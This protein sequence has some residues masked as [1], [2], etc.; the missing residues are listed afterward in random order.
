VQTALVELPLFTAHLSN[1]ATASTKQTFAVSAECLPSIT[2]QRAD[3]S[4]HVSGV[5][6]FCHHNGLRGLT[7]IGLSSSTQTPP[8]QH[9]GEFRGRRMQQANGGINMRGTHVV[10]CQ[11]HADGDDMHLSCVSQH[12]R[13]AVS[14]MLNPESHKRSPVCRRGH[15]G[16][17]QPQS[18]DAA[19]LRNVTKMRSLMHSKM[20]RI[21]QEVSE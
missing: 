20:Q 6:T 18:G 7:D 4:L 2:M 8:T 12:L 15:N 19:K 10:S 16:I 21:K 5:Q 17:Q 11:F 1:F 9:Q 3:R 14:R 13:T